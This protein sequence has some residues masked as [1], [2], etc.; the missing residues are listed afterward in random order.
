MVS[1][2]PPPS[3]YD[4]PDDRHCPVCAQEDGDPCTP[5]SC[6]HYDHK[7]CKHH[8]KRYSEE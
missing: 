4:P 2:S 3:W 1:S 5:D 8:L 7:V 6:D